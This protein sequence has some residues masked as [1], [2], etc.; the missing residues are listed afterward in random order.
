MPTPDGTAPVQ[1]RFRELA[2]ARLPSLVTPGLERLLARLDAAGV[3]YAA[4]TNAP[5][6][7]AELMLDAI[8]R[9]H[10][11]S[12]L[13]IGDECT[14]ANHYGNCTANSQ[15]VNSFGSYACVCNPGYEG[16]GKNSTC[17]R[18]VSAGTS[19]SLVFD[20]F[21]DHLRWD[22]VN[23]SLAFSVLLQVSTLSAKL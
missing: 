18:C 20:G 6:A 23:T 10:A 22:D 1:A 11:F 21:N 19:K 7:N 12:P 13:V 17:T 5:R 8:G 2:A 14:A 4:V 3:P 16:D 15:C 9:R